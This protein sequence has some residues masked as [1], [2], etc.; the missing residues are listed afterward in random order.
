[1]AEKIYNLSKN[2]VQVMQILKENDGLAELLLND[3]KNP[4]SVPVKDKDELINPNSQNCRIKPFPFD[5]EAQ[6]EDSSFIRVY[7]NTGDFNENETIQEMELH[8]DIIVAKSLWLINDGRQSLI[9]PYEIMDR[10]VDLVGKR[11]INN[12]IRLKFDGW[13]HLSV[14]TKFDAIRLYS[15]YYSVEAENHYGYE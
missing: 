1:M 12:L 4:F 11:S 3:I 6:I 15:E 5:P 10:V 2:I 9:R 14:N 13:Q 8:I 7:Y